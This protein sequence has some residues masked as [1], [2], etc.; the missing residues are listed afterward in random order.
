MPRLDGILADTTPLRVSPPFRR[1]W[2]GLGISNLGSQLT[3]VAVGL[4]V[5]ALTGS[6]LAVGVL[7]IFALVPLVAL[8]LYG[9]ALVDAY[10]RR[11]VALL[12]SWALWVVTGLLALQAWFDVG[13]V[14]VLYG[15]VA[16]QSAAFAINNPARSAII[17]RLV[18]PRLLPA[19]NA[20]QTISW[21]IALTV[22]PL[23]GAFLVALWG[24]PV[25]Y[26]IDVVLFAAA[27]WAVW[28]L[29][30]IPPVLT[31][32][33]SEPASTPGHGGSDN[34]SG[35]P[36]GDGAA[37]RRKVVGISSVVDGLRYLA[38]RPNVRTTFL[39]DLAAMILA[40]PRVLLP[41][42]GVLFI[43]GGETT[44]GVL[45]AAFAVGAVLAGVFSGALSRVRWQGLV[46]AW[47]ITAWGLSIAA[48]G[49]V[50]LVVGR[51]EPSHVLV[52][53]LVAA[54]VALALAGA[55]DAV[56][57]VF[58]QTI[59]QT[60]TPDDMRGRLQGVF[61]VVVAGGPRL[62]EVVLG[63]Q[64]S[65]FGEAWA[66]V[67][68]GLACVVVVWLILRAQPRFLR[69]DALHPEP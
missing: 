4:Q 50:L 49:A 27:L 48:F 31:S 2:W 32:D 6:T 25:A 13:S 45:S 65:W 22:G 42:V 14:G 26:T 66:A 59:L 19:A 36:A 55:S 46:I 1:L 20:L 63:A 67:A 24:Y 7:G 57:A 44:T 30:S 52:G 8:G 28:R 56:S 43:G 37:P 29:P 3:V 54:C 16:L 5:Y 34:V 60:A 58:R 62:G 12:A 9:G 61:I 47:A 11:K 39:V 38:T 35:D 18:E 10:D 23:L 53:G 41:A 15:L 51:T 68:G 69:Y 40:F 17:P 21:S 33:V 64:A